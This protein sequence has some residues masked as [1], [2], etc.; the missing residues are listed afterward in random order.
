MS[1]APSVAFFNNKGG[2][3]KTSLVYHLAWMYTNLGE[4][5]LAVDLDP[6]ASLTARFLDEDRLEALWEG[7]APKTIYGAIQPLL[8]GTGDIGEPHLERI[9]QDA[10]LEDSLA[11]LPGDLSLSAF[12]DQLSENW[13]KAVGGDER[14]FRVLG[15]FWRLMRKAAEKHR[16]TI[17]LVDLGPNLGAMNRAALISTDFVVVP[18]SPDLFSLQGLSNLGPQLRQWRGDW[19][20]RRKRNPAPDELEIPSGRMEPLGYIVLQHSV[21]LDRP[22]HAYEKWIRRIPQV[23]R[24]KVL[25]EENGEDLSVQQDSR[26]LALL[27][28]YRSLMPMA[29][30]ARKPMFHLKP[31]DG[32]IGAHFQAV[33]GVY[34]DF[35]QLARTLEERVQASL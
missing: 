7:P 6:Q 27:K 14:A 16:A 4:R 26:C 19:E 35:K 2:V 3:G 34:R 24:H 12:E 29:Q 8:Q 22:V 5:V 1:E 13:P 10:L 23:Y 31:A 30:E 25:G 20:D 15:A 17:I 33:Q 28:H 21:R 18:L 11:L 9:P 32:A